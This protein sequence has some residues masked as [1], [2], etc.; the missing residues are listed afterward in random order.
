MLRFQRM[1]SDGAGLYLRCSRVSTFRMMEALEDVV[2]PRNEHIALCM[3]L[4]CVPVFAVADL[5]SHFIIPIQ[6]PPRAIFAV[7]RIGY[8]KNKVYENGNK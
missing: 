3:A 7:D 1:A 6:G 2:K 5:P 8:G 4:L